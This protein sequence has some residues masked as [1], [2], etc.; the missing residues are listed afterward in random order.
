MS[1]FIGIDYGDVRVGTAISDDTEE[2]A[3][4]DTVIGTS[5]EDAKSLLDRVMSSG[6]ISGVVVGLPLNFG[7]VETEQ[8]AKVR[9]YARRLGALT[10]APIFFENEVL[11]TTAVTKN[12][13][14]KSGMVDA[15]AAALILQQFLDKR[16]KA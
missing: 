7:G 4:P 9:E 11:T 6:G 16:R 1:R 2:F 3:F 12:N 5:D 8:T 10:N 14:A 13:A 15:S